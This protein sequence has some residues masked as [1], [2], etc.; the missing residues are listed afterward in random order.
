MIRSL[1]RFVPPSL[2]EPVMRYIERVGPVLRGEGDP[3]RPVEQLFGAIEESG[4]VRYL[5]SWLKGDSGLVLLIGKSAH[6]RKIVAR[7]AVSLCRTLASNERSAPIVEYRKH[8][9]ESALFIAAICWFRR[10]FHVVSL[11][12]QGKALL[13][14]ARSTSGEARFNHVKRLVSLLLNDLLPEFLKSLAYLEAVR[15]N[16]S[17]VGHGHAETLGQLLRGLRSSLPGVAADF[18]MC[19]AHHVRNAFAHGH[20]HWD[21]VSDC[22]DLSDKGWS[23]RLPTEELLLELQTTFENVV[24]AAGVVIASGAAYVLERTYEEVDFEL[25][26]KNQVD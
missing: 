21:H 17:V 18:T 16:K 24:A 14:L 7:R 23:R 20:A 1:L 19:D 11:I 10:P 5:D 2:V 13:R 3:E 12:I 8:F 9:D 25:L 26:K 22:V 4:V 6:A 15:T